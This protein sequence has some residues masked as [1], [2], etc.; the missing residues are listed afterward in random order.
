M[1][2]ALRKVREIRHF[3]LQSVADYAGIAFSRLE[4]FE[5]GTRAPSPRQL[6]RLAETYG[7]A[8]YL[9]DADLTPNLPETVAD[10]RRK[11]PRPAHLSP[12]GMARLW[13]AE[14]VS[15]STAQLLN[16]LEIGRPVWSNDCPRGKLDVRLASNTRAF[17]NEWKRSR[18]AKLELTGTDEQRFLASFRLFVEAQGTIVRIND[19]PPNDYYGFFLA[20]EAGLPTVFINRKILAPKAQLFTLLHEYC[21]MLLGQAGV[22]NPFVVKNEIERQ[23]N[24]FAAEFLAPEREFSELAGAQPKTVRA[25]LFRF[26]ATV[27]SQSLLSMHATAIRLLETNFISQAQLNTWESHRKTLPIKQLKDEEK[28]L[29]SQDQKGGAVHAKILGEIGYLPVYVAKLAVD[30]KFIDSADVHAGFH[31]TE[32]LQ[33]KAFSLAARRFEVAFG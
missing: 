19:A 16:P 24:K 17:F 33:E 23:C 26:I 1:T 5:S 30:R 22:S 20:P 12:A 9:L 18:L 7:L 28:D 3:D 14:E 13:S 32:S 29:E 21:H 6:E 8:S 4:E 31:L 27:S 11:H 25:D 10:F 2:I 15:E